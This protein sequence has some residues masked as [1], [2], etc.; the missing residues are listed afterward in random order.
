MELQRPI[1]ASNFKKYEKKTK[2]FANLKKLSK[3]TILL[4]EIAHN[5]SYQK[6][7]DTYQK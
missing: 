1:S 2:S 7:R 5:F 6:V 4:T 3:T